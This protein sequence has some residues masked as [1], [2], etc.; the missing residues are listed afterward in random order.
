MDLYYECMDEYLIHGPQESSQ[1]PLPDSRFQ[2]L[3]GRNVLE[4]V[5]QI[6]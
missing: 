4:L 5:E 6:L 2:G 3:G 1:A